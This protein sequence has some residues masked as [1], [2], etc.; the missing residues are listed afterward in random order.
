MIQGGPIIAAPQRSS[1]IAWRM[2]HILK[3][4]GYCSNQE[5]H[6]HDDTS[7]AHFSQAFSVTQ[8]RSFQS[9]R[10]KPGVRLCQYILLYQFL[11]TWCFSQIQP[12]MMSV[13]PNTNMLSTVM[14][15]GRY[16]GP[17]PGGCGSIRSI[18]LWIAHAI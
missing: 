6:V 11:E 13:V 8:P 18:D 4:T 5:V 14:D 12:P 1:G 9:S 3:E 17:L 7:I 10:V 16:H 2:Q 15:T